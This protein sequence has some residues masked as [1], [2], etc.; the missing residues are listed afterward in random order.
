MADQDGEIGLEIFDATPEQIAEEMKGTNA[1]ATKPAGNEPP[2]EPEV[3]AEGDVA[4]SES[5][6]ENVEAEVEGE[7][8]AATEP[9]QIALAD[10]DLVPIKQD[11]K[12]VYVRWG[13]YNGNVMRI[14][15]YTRKTTAVSAREKEIES[16]FT[17]LQERE[18]KLIDLASNPEKLEKLYTHITKGKTLAGVKPAAATAPTDDELATA[19]DI[20]RTKEEVIAETRVAVENE[21]RRIEQERAD[22]AQEQFVGTLVSTTEEMLDA[23]LKDHAE[24]LGDIPYVDSIIKKK[25]WADHQPKSLEEVRKA[26]VQAAKD[27]STQFASKKLQSKKIEVAQKAKLDKGIEP[28][29]GTP[30]GRERK[31]YETKDG[32]PDWDAL[33][34][35]VINWI[36]ARRKA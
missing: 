26:I 14:A 34:R 16:V 6:E 23:V 10:D 9:K 21:I 28:K 35:D 3:E 11:G 7:K 13:D 24:T 18:Q 29:G 30:P 1:V 4:E 31:T 8:P 19:G 27:L 36:D 20:R 5:H 2:A 25:A 22:L 15:D 33:D 12:V 17:Q 32:K